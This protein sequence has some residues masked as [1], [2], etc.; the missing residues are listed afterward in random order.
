M[1]CKTEHMPTQKTIAII[2]AATE[3]GAAAAENLA[4]GGYRLLLLSLSPSATD[5]HR[6]LA[7]LK[8]AVGQADIEAMACTSEAAWE[9]D[10]IVLA[11]ADQEL[12]ALVPAISHF[13]TGKPVIWIGDDRTG[14]HA[15]RLASFLPYCHIECCLADRLTGRIHHIFQPQNQI[16]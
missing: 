6:L 13:I 1:L 3:E 2:G 7:R 10:M 12:P 15:S 11:I 14:A 4:G 8:K 5:L 16:I 9:A